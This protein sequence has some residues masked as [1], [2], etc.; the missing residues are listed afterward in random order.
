MASSG[1]TQPTHTIQQVEAAGAQPEEVQVTGTQYVDDLDDA[2]MED[3]YDDDIGPICVVSLSQLSRLA[4]GLPHTV[5]ELPGPT[6]HL[7]RYE[8]TA[9]IPWADE[10]PLHI[11]SVYSESEPAVY[12]TQPSSS[13]GTSVE[14][15]IPIESSSQ[16]KEGE[17][18]QGAA[19]QEGHPP[20]G[21]PVGMPHVGNIGILGGPP[22]GIPWVRQVGILGGPPAG[23]PQVGQ[24]GIL[25]GPPA[26]PQVGPQAVIPYVAP[27]VLIPPQVV[28][29]VVIP[30][31]VV[32]PVVIPP[33]VGL[34]LNLLQH[35][36]PQLVLQI[37]PALQLY[38]G[39]AQ[40]SVRTL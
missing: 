2:F 19:Q 30:P 33:Q 17:A 37:H 6:I 35:Q 38:V 18:A 14:V 34:I 13:L 31:Q 10:I 7:V 9:S 36:A 12:V 25:G 23:M 29:P 27:P 1:E 4:L 28:P 39:N 16:V 3:I 22:A 26:V 11:P 8:Q 24:V 5:V 40:L 21:P 20:G 15:Q 32:P